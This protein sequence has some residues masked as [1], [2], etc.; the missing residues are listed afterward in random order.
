MHLD[1]ETLRAY[2]DQQLDN[3]ESVADHLSTCVPCGARLDEMQAR[4]ARVRAQVLSLDPLPA[5]SA[6]PASVA[7]ARLYAKNQAPSRKDRSIMLNTIFAQRLR[8]LWIGASILALFAVA[9]SF[10]P[11]RAWA[12][13][14]LAQFR[15]Q[16]VA[17]VPVD[18]TRLNEVLGNSP[19]S[20]QIGQL[21]S[22]T[23]TVTAKPGKAR[24]AA[25]AAQASQ[26]AGFPVRLPT[27][28]SDAPQLTVEGGL[29]FQVVV[30][31]T[32]AQGLL[33]EAGFSRYQLP[34]SIDGATIK[35]DIPS[36]VSAGYGE[37]PKPEDL[38]NLEGALGGTSGS[39]STQGPSR[40]QMIKCT[41]LVQVPSPTVDAPSNLDI[42]GLA[43][44][45]LEFSGMTA[46]QARAFSQTVDW[47]STLVI[48]IPRNG[49]SYKQVQVD[50]VTGYM[51]QRPAEDAPEYAIIWVKN[52]I[53]Y[54]IAGLGNNVDTALGM[55]NSMK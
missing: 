25:N 43:Q 34:A 39:P 16:K 7:L 6:P 14:L 36:G 45:A 18:N 19:L 35:V 52:G 17:V 5:E 11:V 2:L 20:K 44:M 42:K 30:N 38:E 54:A 10:P 9:F 24:A 49:S 8:P 22:D 1:D 28:R 31:R 32:R 55:A 47:T 33:N 26:M 21:L 48:P 46:D 50:G 3:A 4:S 40:R 27:N 13:D 41:M 15:V 37:C 12:S 51:I 23:M 29:G 53:V